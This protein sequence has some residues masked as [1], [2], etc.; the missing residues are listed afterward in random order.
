MFFHSILK[1]KCTNNISCFYCNEL[2]LCE[3]CNTEAGFYPKS[4]ETRE[5]GYINCYKDPEGYFLKNN[6]TYE[7]CYSSCKYCTDLGNEYDNKCIECNSGFEV[8][9]EF[10][11]D[12]N[13][14]K[15]CDYLLQNR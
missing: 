14:Y 3:S 15:K 2:N 7:R 11:N 6:E 5:D 10:P 8:K 12:T 1:C 4:D 13:C 9:N